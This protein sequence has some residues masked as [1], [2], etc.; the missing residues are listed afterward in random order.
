M[1]GQ[2]VNLINALLFSISNIY[3]FYCQIWNIIIYIT[4]YDKCINMTIMYRG[5]SLASCV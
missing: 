3:N 1:L 2:L 4:F 5:H